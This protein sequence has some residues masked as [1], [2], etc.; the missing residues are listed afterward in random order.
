MLGHLLNTDSAYSVKENVPTGIYY[1]FVLNPRISNELLSDYKTY[2]R[3]WHGEDLGVKAQKDP[4]VLVKYVTDRIQISTTANYA[5]TPMLPAGVH[6]LRMADPVSRDIYFVALCRSFGIPARIDP[7]SGTL[8][9]YTRG[10]WQE[11]HFAS[12]SIQNSPKSEL[13]LVADSLEAGFV[14]VYYQHFTIAR[15]NDGFYRSLDYEESPLLKNFPAT[16]SLDTG[17]YLI[18]TGV[19]NTDGSVNTR[20]EFFRLRPGEKLSKKLIFNTKDEAPEPVG[21][22]GLQSAVELWPDGKSKILSEVSADKGLILMWV[23]PG[24]E[25]TRHT[26]SDIGLLRNHFV[27]WGGGFLVMPAPGSSLNGLTAEEKA[28]LPGNAALAVDV[29]VLLGYIEKLTN[30]QFQGNFPVC[31]MVDKEG[32]IIYLSSGYKIGRG[33]QM[34]KL[35]KYLK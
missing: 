19:R 18:L 6:E 21:S 2:F 27:K 17:Y 32:K 7:A 22:I 35:L 24:K 29:S 16:L 1:D 33:E 9:Y 12:Q 34:A 15:F 23:E 13:I 5:R 25:P 4:A 14:P 28:G 31:I 3:D 30:R 8:A 11:V 10:G 20:T 26:L